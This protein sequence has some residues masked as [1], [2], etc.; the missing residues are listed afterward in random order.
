MPFSMPTEDDARV[1]F[2]RLSSELE[3]IRKAVAPLRA[4]YEKKRVE[5]MERDEKELQPLR[6]KMLDA[7]SESGLH[8]KAQTLAALSRY[9][10]GQTALPEPKAEV[11]A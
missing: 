1:E 11:E 4:A 8:E 3:T 9:L 10:K 2:H 5:L 7:E 6:R